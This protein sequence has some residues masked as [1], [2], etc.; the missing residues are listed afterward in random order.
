MRKTLSFPCISVFRG[1]SKHLRDRAKITSPFLAGPFAR[2][3]RCSLLTDPLP[4]YAR[5]SRL[6]SG[7]NSCAMKG[8]VIFAQSLSRGFGGRVCLARG[9]TA[10]Q[11]SLGWHTEHYERTPT[12]Q[13][14]AL[15]GHFP[16][17][18]GGLRPCLRSRG[19][20]IQVAALYDLL[21]REF[22]RGRQG[23]GPTGH[24]G[25]GG[26]RR[27]HDLHQR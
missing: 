21:G 6:A 5:R 18:L 14:R 7:Q 12:K 2:R 23:V 8:E 1:S 11:C 20:R 13:P 25:Y 19:L 10:G 4:G 15:P 3:L 26:G 24:P 9:I 17:P 27:R 22:L 16:R